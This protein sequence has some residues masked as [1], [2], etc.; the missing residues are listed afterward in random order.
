MA[1]P[2]SLEPFA[3]LGIRAWMR[4]IE[5]SNGTTQTGQ[6]VQVSGYTEQWTTLHARLGARGDME[7]SQTKLVFIEAGVKLPLYNENTAYLSTTGL[8]PDVT[9][10]P[11]RQPSLFIEAGILFLRMG[12]SIKIN[13][14]KAS[15]FYDGMRFS[16]SPDVV[17]QSHITYQPRSTAD[18]YGVK[19]GILF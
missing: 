9:M 3:G 5:N 18:I 6:P 1:G 17:K 11:G 10:H 7:I 2:C 8:A 13:R 15:V 12:E 14:V 4:H 16:R 19:M